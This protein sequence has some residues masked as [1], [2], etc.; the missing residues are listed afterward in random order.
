MR[1]L[2]I[3]AKFTIGQD[4]DQSTA[5]GEV[6][7]HA[8]DRQLQFLQRLPIQRELAAVRHRFG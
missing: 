7:P 5:H 3:H 2:T 1:K 6:Y 4:L 8:C